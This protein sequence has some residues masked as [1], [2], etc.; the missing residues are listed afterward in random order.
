MLFN[1]IKT[2]EVLNAAADNPSDGVGVGAM[3]GA[4]IGLGAGLPL[5]NQLGQKL[6]ISNND[7]PEIQNEKLDPSERIKKLK[8]LFDQ[9]LITEEQFNEKR[10]AILKEL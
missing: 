1:A 4:G 9:N 6:D 2:F 10:E 5:G 3:L 8:E 7:K